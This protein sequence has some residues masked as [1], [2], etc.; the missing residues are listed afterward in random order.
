MEVIT[1]NFKGNTMPEL[2]VAFL[3]SGSTINGL[4]L[5]LF[6]SETGYWIYILVWLPNQ[7]HAIITVTP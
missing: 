2:F 1:V 6:I 5:H 3:F 4:S 7:H